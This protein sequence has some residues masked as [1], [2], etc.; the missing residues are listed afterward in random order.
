MTSYKSSFLEL[1]LEARA[2]KFG[3]FKLKSGRVSPY[4]FNASAFSTGTQLVVLGQ[5]YRD[6]IEASGI[7]FDGLFGPAYKGIPLATSVAHA[8]SSIGRDIPV[9]FNRKETKGHAEGGKLLGSALSGRILAIDDVVTAGT[10]IRES[11][12]FVHNHGAYLSAICVAVDRQERGRNGSKS[13]F[14]ELAE[15][16]KL[17]TISI[18]CLDD[19]L[20]F[21]DSDS[22]IS[23]SIA[24]SIEAY[25]EEYG[26]YS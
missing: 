14:V 19:I 12:E 21:A 6:A 1:A 13:A 20:S 17:R 2:L 22:R 25:R 5:C 23:H 3:E 9:S 7:N 18:V 8:F 26:V 15:T 11:A 10:A 4:F 24:S 16:L